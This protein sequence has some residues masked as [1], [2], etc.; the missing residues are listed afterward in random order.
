[1][2]DAAGFDDFCEYCECGSPHCDGSCRD[3]CDSCGSTRCRGECC[4]LSP[5]DEDQLQAI[6]CEIAELERELEELQAREKEIQGK[7]SS[8]KQEASAL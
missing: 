3:E 4:D 2:L 7:L 1:M 6:D 5:E 8:L